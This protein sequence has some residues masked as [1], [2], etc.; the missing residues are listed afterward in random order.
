MLCCN[1]EEP[2]GIHSRQP[3][4]TPWRQ[5]KL[6]SWKPTHR[7][8]VL[9]LVMFCISVLFVPIG[10][11]L[12]TTANAIEF[13]TD[14]TDCESI[15]FAPITCAELRNNQSR[16]SEA[17]TCRYELTLTHP[18]PGDVTFYYGIDNFFQNHRLYVKSRDDVQLNGV[19]QHTVDNN[20][21]PYHQDQNGI[22]IA[23]CGAIANGMFNDTFTLRNSSS[24]VPID[25]TG[26]TRPRDKGIKLRNPPGADVRD[27]FDGFSKPFFWQNYTYELDVDDESNNG[28]LN[29]A[30]IVWMRLAAFYN[31]RKK[32][33]RLS[34]DWDGLS[35]GTYTVTIEYNYPVRSY[36]GRKRFII[37]A[38]TWMGSKNN[39]L[40]FAYL[41]LGAICFLAG[42]ILIVVKHRFNAINANRVNCTE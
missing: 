22:L 20:C 31:F 33:G 40:G 3:K 38:D 32:Y 19:V 10:I 8:E 27:A 7:A 6:R 36:D 30:F 29:E 4:E 39:F 41:V 28:Y 34:Q 11:I 23:P 14:Y 5:Q 24:N 12:L 18:L 17:C 15:Q 16:M 1:N 37:S 42:V 2:E 35:V 26:I 21:R 13:A 9:T 25:R